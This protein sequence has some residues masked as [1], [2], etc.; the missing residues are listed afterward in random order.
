MTERTMICPLMSCRTTSID[1]VESKT[2]TPTVAK[3]QKETC[4]LWDGAENVCCFK[5]ISM[6]LIKINEAVLKT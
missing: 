2:L 5:S 3:C 1:S 4:A 6:Q